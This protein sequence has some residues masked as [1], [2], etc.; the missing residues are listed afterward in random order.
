MEV[1]E[2]AL[3]N[4][5]RGQVPKS[6]ELF[7]IASYFGVSMEYLLA[8][9]GD[10]AG[11]GWAVRE[12]APSAKLLEKVD[13]LAKEIEDRL[14]EMREAIAVEEARSQMLRVRPPEME[15]SRRSAG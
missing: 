9:K 6:M 11:A 14:A 12:E 15:R 5:R 7:R 2:G 1:S 3:I 8:G 4:Y 13:R 10:T